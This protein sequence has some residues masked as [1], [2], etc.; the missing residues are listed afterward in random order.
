MLKSNEIYVG[1]LVRDRAWHDG[2]FGVISKLETEMPG[3][4]GVR[5][6]YY[7][8]SNGTD[9]HFGLPHQFDPVNP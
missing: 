8:Y 1:A 2:K 4:F 9:Y 5:Y 7:K 3:N 6:F